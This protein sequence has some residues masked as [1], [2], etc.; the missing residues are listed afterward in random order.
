M[1]FSKKYVFESRG[2]KSKRVAFKVFFVLGAAFFSFLLLCLYLPFY[3]S[4]ENEKAEASFFK[5]SPDA[6]VV[7]T[8]DVGRI[9]YALKKVR[10][11]EDTL[12][13]ISGVYAANT[14]K[15]LVTAQELEELKLRQVEIDYL[16]RNTHEN[17]FYTLRYLRGHPFLKHVLIISSDYH[18]FRIQVLLMR[19]RSPNSKVHFYFQGTSSDFLSWR[20]IRILMTEGGKVIKTVVSL[21]GWDYYDFPGAKLDSH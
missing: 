11:S 3:A 20:G 6:I 10:E 21:I 9:S 15:T 2:T 4:K 14:L 13:L 5:K 8:G 12:A 19:M 17:V 16:A 18:L 1:V 7:F